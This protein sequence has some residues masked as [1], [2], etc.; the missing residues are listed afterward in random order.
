MRL[1]QR[2][3]ALLYVG[4]ILGFCP[5]ARASVLFQSIPD[6]TV[7]PANFLCSD[8]GDGVEVFGTFTLTSTA[9]ITGIEF[10]VQQYFQ[11]P[12]SISFFAYPSVVGAFPN[13][14]IGTLEPSTYSLVSE[15]NGTDL[16]NVVLPSSLTLDVGTYDISF[17]G[18]QFLVPTYASNSGSILTSAYGELPLSLGFALDGTVVQGVPELSTWRMLLLGF[19]AVGFNRRKS[20]PALMAA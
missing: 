14:L 12:V 2:F 15:Q 8:C 1:R 16:R 9:T 6:L 11:N 7:A 3:A 20:K 5:P 18:S 13:Q 19:V 17:V 4:V 10:A